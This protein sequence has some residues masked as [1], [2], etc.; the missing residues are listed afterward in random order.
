MSFVTIS[1]PYDCDSE[2]EV[3]YDP[4]A[5]HTAGIAI[6]GI[7]AKPI[8]VHGNPDDPKIGDAVLEAITDAEEAAYDREVDRR[9]DRERDR[10]ADDL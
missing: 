5:W 10:W 7:A 6:H 1:C 4:K 3:E 9:V 2:L 8:C